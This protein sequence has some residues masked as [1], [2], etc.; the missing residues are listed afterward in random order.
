MSLTICLMIKDEAPYLGEWLAFHSL[1]GVGHFRIY[2]NGSTDGTLDLL[3]RLRW[4]FNIEVVPWTEAGITRQQS[5]F[6]DAARRLAGLWDWVAFLDADEF[7][8]DPSFRPLPAVLAAMPPDVGAVAVN[9]RVFGS[10]GLVD[11]SDESV[12]RRFARRARNDYAEHEWI[13]TVAR[14][15]CIDSFH[16][17]H[18]ARLS[19]GRYVLADGEPF[20][21]KGA[22]PGHAGRIAK[23]GLVLH[24][25]IL[26]SL[27][28][29]RRKQ[30]RGAVSDRQGYKR[31]TDDYFTQRDA[32]INVEEDTTLVAIADL[33]ETRLRFALDM[34]KSPDGRGLAPMPTN[35]PI[36]LAE[37][38]HAGFYRPD[39]MNLSWI[40]Q[41]EIGRITFNTDAGLAQVRIVAYLATPD[42]PAERVTIT[43]NGEPTTFSVRSHTGNWRSFETEPVA[44]H[45]GRNE[46]ELTSPLFIAVRDINPTALDSRHIGI[47]VTEMTLLV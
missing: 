23:R 4:H 43:V 3:H 8:F 29:F 44:L 39:V 38:P 37:L 32:N 18:S 7:L 20:A 11:L 6:N 2:D 14:P 40:R 26:K 9:Q 15:Q 30:Q 42:Y 13:K 1:M 34:T 33:V 19:S 31:L 36:R 5:A 17:S 10:S 41:D 24:H 27:A 22:H 25:Y 21:Q 28:E 12:I 35:R 45:S 46:V 47:A 16:L